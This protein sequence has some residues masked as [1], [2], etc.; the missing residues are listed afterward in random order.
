ME[1]AQPK[2][3]MSRGK[4]AGIIVGA[5][6]AL[7]IAAVLVYGFVLTRTGYWLIA[8]FTPDTPEQQLSYT[9]ASDTVRQIAE[10]GFV[11]MQNNDDLLPLASTAENPGKINLFGIRSIQMVYNGG[12]SAASDVTKCTRLEEALEGQNFALNPNLLNVYYNFF[13]TGEI[14]LEPGKEP[15][16][17]GASEFITTPDSITIPELP[18]SAFTDTSLYEDGKTL[19]EHAKEYSDVAVV[20]LSRS[21]GE[22]ADLDVRDLQLT[23]EEIALLDAVTGTFDDVVLIL[24]C[25][26]TMELGFIRD[27][28]QIKSVLWVG[29][30]GETGNL[31]TASILSGAVN[32]SGRTADTWVTDN[33]SAPAANNFRELQS[34][35]TWAANSFHY[36]NVSDN[37]DVSEVLKALGE[38]TTIRGFFNHYAE[39]IYVGYKYYE[40]RHD[41]DPSYDYDAEVVY[42]FGHG[43]SYTTFD[44]KIMAMNVEDGVITVRVEVTNTGDVA[45]KDVLE[46]YFNAPYTGAIEKSTVNLVAFKKTNLIEP[47][48]TEHYSI[49]FALED[50]ASYDYKVN[51]S[52]VLEA[53]DYVISLRDDAHTVVDEETWT[54][55]NDIIYNDEHDGKRPS[56]QQTAVNQFDSALGQD[57]YLTRAW[58]ES[59]R[60]FTGPLEE[61]YTAD[62]SVID[63]LTWTNPTDAELGLTE[64]DMPATGVKLDTTLMLSDMVGVD[65]D[66]P[67]WDEFVSQLTVEE[68]ATLCTSG[69]YTIGAIDRLGVPLSATPD[70][71][72]GMMA[73]AWSGPIMGV[74]GSGV[75]YPTE[76][77]L[78]SSWNQDLAE[79]MGS[80]V[81][82]EAQALGFSGWYAPG[83]NTH[84]TAFSGRNWEYYSEDG[85]LA[86]EIGGSVVKGATEKGVICYIK[87]FA[88]NEREA[89][90][91]QSLFTWSNEQAIREIY[92]KPFEIAVK[93]GG[94]LGVMS[95]FNYIG[96]EWCGGNSALL[97]QV[98]RNEWGFD[99]VVITDSN[100][101]SYMYV[102][103]M[104][105]AG[106]DLSLDFMAAFKLPGGDD[107]KNRLLAAA[108]NP[109]TKVG[110]TLELQ[111]ASKDIL[112]AVSNTWKMQ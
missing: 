2:K 91:R 92:L 102:D 46:I 50:M 3:K 108:E 19:M 90:N 95:A 35:G 105:Y 80:T 8:K 14:S 101:Y 17:G 38:D 79:L 52:Y 69:G 7:L 74:S 48:T 6:L 51:K 99:G 87:H 78:A 16:N 45:G 63:A 49:E 33:L 86:G 44:K 112:Y 104:L 15:A 62:Q 12:G 11:L 40:T 94:S 89:E 4:K 41:T 75:T 53:G 109:D 107:Q 68:M 34:D 59:G 28:P 54:L 96:Y 71:P 85:V 30:P 55:S 1:N 81:G 67:K 23:D 64:A 106:G 24:N 57:D 39:G 29:F 82:S 18:V 73:N 100:R 70:G 103:Q 72:S 36:T 76:V 97:N 47:G 32:P 10:E 88:L 42:P 43:L 25:A 83:M 26:N 77:V 9:Y 56:D 65:K 13:N 60:A 66:D 22:H 31:A 27:Y 20:V 58:D 5:I 98:L 111:R 110:F 37:P 61:D 21:A 84:R 93:K